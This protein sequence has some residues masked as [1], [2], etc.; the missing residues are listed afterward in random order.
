MTWA[1]VPDSSVKYS[2]CKAS[3]RDETYDETES[4]IEFWKMR[5]GQLRIQVVDFKHKK[6]KKFVYNVLDISPKK[7]REL[8]RWLE[9][10][11]ALWEPEIRESK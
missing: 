5:K 10:D 2:K 1:E 7:K 4:Y 9:Q 3:F 6:R 8:I 11:P